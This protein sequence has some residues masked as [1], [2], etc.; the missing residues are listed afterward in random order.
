MAAAHYLVTQAPWGPHHT[1]EVLA[2]LT[3]AGI[4]AL[5]LYPALVARYPLTADQWALLPTPC[6]GLGAA[7]PRVLQRSEAEAA[8]LVRHMSA[9]EQQHLRALALYLGVAQRRGHLPSLPSPLSQGLLADCAA[10]FAG[11]PPEQQAAWQQAWLT[12]RQRLGLPAVLAGATVAAAA[13]GALLLRSPHQ[14][15]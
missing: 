4:T 7:L 6:P 1:A 5:P 13:A 15:E 14:K 2:S 11:L 9:A 8:L 12:K 10:H 3:T